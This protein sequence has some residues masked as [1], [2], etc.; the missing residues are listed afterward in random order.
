MTETSIHTSV[1]RLRWQCRRGMLEL[2]YL[3]RDFLDQV[4]PDL[5]AEEQA[6]F[7]RM[8]DIEDRQLLAW[9]VGDSEPDEPEVGRMIGRMQGVYQPRG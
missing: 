2:D 1:E 4:Y 6:L 7:V 3:L 5:T 8:L 9:L